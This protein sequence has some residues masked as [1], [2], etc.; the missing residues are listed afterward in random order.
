MGALETIK[1]VGHATGPIIAGFLIGIS[2]YFNSFLIVCLIL[3][4]DLAVIFGKLKKAP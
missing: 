3:L 4:V 1:D 2:G